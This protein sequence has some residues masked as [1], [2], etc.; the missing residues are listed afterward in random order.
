MHK[1]PKRRRRVM[2]VDDEEEILVA[3]E[4]FL[5]LHGYQVETFADPRQALAR[6]RRES[7]HVILLDINMPLLDGISLLHTIKALRPGAQVVMMT[8]YSTLEKVRACVEAG[9]VDYIMKPFVDLQ[10]TLNI[11]RLSC[12]RVER[13]ESAGSR[14]IDALLA[15]PDQ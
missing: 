13:W 10:E 7:F 11:L 1:E 15:L 3:I 6:V 14:S 5:R 12:E 4:T 9:A 8:A 2:V